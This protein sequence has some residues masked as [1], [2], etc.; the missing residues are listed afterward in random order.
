MN[1]SVHFGRRRLLTMVAAASLATGYGF[2]TPPGL[3]AG[4]D[5]LLLS[6]SPTAILSDPGPAAQLQPAAAWT[7]PKR[8]DLAVGCVSAAG[9]IDSSGRTHVAAE[10]DGRIRYSVAG[11]NGSWSTTVFI[12][13][14]NRLE[15]APA[16]AFLGNAVYVA[17][18]RVAP[19]DGCGNGYSDLGVYY[20]KRVLPSGTWSAPTRIGSVDDGLSGFRAA[21]STLYATVVNGTNGHS[22]YE[23]RTGSTFHR[24]LISGATGP[25]ALRIGSDGKARVA[26]RTNAG[27]R[28]GVFSGGTLASKLIGGSIP[29]DYDPVLVLDAAN[30]AHVLWTHSPYAD[31]GCALRDVIPHDGTYYATNLS[32]SWKAGR[33]T[34]RFGLAALAINNATHRVHVLVADGTGLRYYTKIPGWLLDDRHAPGRKCPV[35]RDPVATGDREVGRRVHPGHRDRGA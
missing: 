16:I 23:T 14:A 33:I 15:Q 6:S 24:Y 21:G 10:C 3:A 20:R 2:D 7:T 34:H 13:P 22:Y 27:I 25:A 8:V 17:Y 28:Y 11:A 19:Q 12:P 5:G 9:G 32:G 29:E 26:Y 30:N 1:G 18:T 31:P 4:S 35:T